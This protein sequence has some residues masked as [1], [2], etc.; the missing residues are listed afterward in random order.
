[1]FTERIKYLDR[2]IQPGL[3][4]LTWS[5]R[6]VAEAFVQDCRQQASKV[7]ITKMTWLPSFCACSTTTYTTTTTTTTVLANVLASIG[8]LFV[9]DYPGESV[10]EG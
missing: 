6:T 8:S 9:R 10:P 2:K 3:T 1:M 5:A 7:D 4:K